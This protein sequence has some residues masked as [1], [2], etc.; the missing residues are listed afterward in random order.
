MTQLAFLILTGDHSL[1]LPCAIFGDGSEDK[2]ATST[3]RLHRRSSSRG[4]VRGFIP[5]EETL[6]AS[7]TPPAIRDPHPSARPLAMQSQPTRAHHEAG[8]ANGGT[9]SREGSST[10]SQ[11]QMKVSNR[12]FTVVCYEGFICWEGEPSPP[13]IQTPLPPPG[14][15]ISGNVYLF[16]L[17]MWK[18]SKFASCMCVTH[19]AWRSKENFS[20]RMQFQIEHSL[21]YMYMC[22]C[23][24][25]VARTLLGNP[26]NYYT[27]G[28][29]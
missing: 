13:N 25:S 23:A 18:Q 26:S 1:S 17:R 28:S 29:V 2:P 16:Y 24:I 27:V 20:P 4:S 3:P 11:S 5:P 8:E 6:M 21:W 12:L 22:V 10:E 19:H 7:L 9:S 14:K 15:T